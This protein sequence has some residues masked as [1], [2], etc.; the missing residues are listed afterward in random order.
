MYSSHHLD[1]NKTCRGCLSQEE[2]M[3][4]VFEHRNDDLPIISAMLE[5][6]TSVQ[7]NK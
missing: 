1:L 4:S 2:S 6:C 5:S 7:V 3:I